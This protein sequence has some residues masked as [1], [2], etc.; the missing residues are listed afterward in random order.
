[1]SSAPKILKGITWG[2]SR[3][4]VPLQACSQRI[5]EL[6]PD[7][8]IQ[9]KQR[10]LQEFADFPIEKLTE[11]YDLL[12]IDHPW[13]GCAAEINCV[14]PLNEYLSQDFMQNQQ[15]HQV[16]GS[17]D[18]YNYK[19]KQWAL[20]V[21]AATPVASY[22]KDLLEQQNVE[23]PT[24]WE[25]VLHL[26]GKGRVAAPGIPIDLLMNFY[27]FCQIHGETPFESQDIVVSDAVAEKALETMKE[28]Y[29]L[30]DK[31]LF[32]ANP[33][34]V[35]E[36]MSTTNRYWYCPFA[37]GYSN[38]SRAG[39]AK[40]SL[41]YT[42]IVNYNNVPMRST[43]GGTGLAIS[44]FSSYK[45]EALIFAERLASEHYQ[46]TEYIMNG[47]QPGHR[48]AWLNTRNNALT[49]NFFL[50]TIATLDNAYLRPRYYGY[51]E[52]QDRAGDYVQDFLLGKCSI[53]SGI[54]KMNEL[55]RQSK[56]HI[57]GQ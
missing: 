48:K 19:G 38:Y 26:A 27:M 49:D 28:F 33:I 9:W 17:H 30:L 29:S 10:S 37:Y 20:A 7:I 40:Y 31:E 18:S 52:F 36:L 43:L 47:G 39:Y 57:D 56:N 46:S 54:E 3:G 23:I 16:G 55:Y 24:S 50:N 13:V 51:L 2:H 53:G 15:D 34:K 21:D 6:Y 25:E 35:A 14:L 4:I 12:I 5:S 32:T 11:H 1:M 42:N 22:R 41:H 8:Q 44:S 45:E